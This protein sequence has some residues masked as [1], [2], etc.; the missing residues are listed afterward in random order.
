MP[1]AQN[2]TFQNSVTPREKE[3]AI[4][5]VFL[6][7]S[8]LA[9]LCSHSRC[10]GVVI[11]PWLC[12]RAVFVPPCHYCISTFTPCCWS[13]CVFIW[14]VTSVYHNA[15][16]VGVDCFLNSQKVWLP[17]V[18]RMNPD[19]DITTVRRVWAFV[20]VCAHFYLNV[21]KCCLFSTTAFQE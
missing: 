16:C 10:L 11:K 20:K 2:A 6:Q 19:C 12:V 17:H 4:N 9:G 18:R 21:H 13:S 3:W 1:E 8:T 15:I 7:N 14:L 5:K